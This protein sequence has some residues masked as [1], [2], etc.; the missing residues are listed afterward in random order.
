MSPNISNAALDARRPARV[1]R[2]RPRWLPCKSRQCVHLDLYGPLK[3]LGDN[4]H[5]LCTTDAFSKIAVVMPIPDK[6]ASTVAQMILDRWIYQFAPPAQIHSDGGKEFVN[7]MSAKFFAILDIKHTKMTPAHPQC[8]AQ[9]E[10][11]NCGIKEYLSPYQHD[12]TLDW[13]KFLPAMAFAYNTCYQSTIGTTLIQL[14]HGFPADSM[15]FQPKAQVDSRHLFA[16]K[17]ARLTNLVKQ[18]PA[19]VQHSEVQKAQQKPVF[20][21]HAE[22]HKFL[23]HQQVLVHVHDFLNKIENW[24]FNSKGPTKSSNSLT[25]MP[26]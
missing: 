10:N 26:S 11:F 6:E 25:T 14:M 8:N 19:A 7:K 5:V 24:L 17:T 23:L 20:D 18:R 3:S 22:I 1:I 15:G 2:S 12:H 16:D 13:D 4:E 9:V 21:H